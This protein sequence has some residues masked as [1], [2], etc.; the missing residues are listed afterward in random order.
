MAKEKYIERGGVRFF[1]LHNAQDEVMRLLASG[2]KILGIDA[3]IIDKS[4]TKPVS[5]LSVDL[6]HI[7]SL[8]ESGVR[9][10]EHLKLLEGTKIW[11][12]IVY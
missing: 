2:R 1:E 11:V 12:E 5:A 10:L 7:S 3:F 4:V 8:T 9:A 6:S